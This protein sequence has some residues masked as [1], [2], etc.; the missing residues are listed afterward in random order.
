MDQTIYE[1]YQI[2]P[3]EARVE[4]NIRSLST[5]R[6]DFVNAQIAIHH[7]MFEAKEKLSLESQRRKLEIERLQLEL[8][9]ENQRSEREMKD[10][11]LLERA[12]VADLTETAGKRIEK[13]YAS[14]SQEAEAIRSSQRRQFFEEMAKLV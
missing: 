6:Q 14:R 13:L 7:R 9:L 12:M 1:S 10:L 8:N 3:I 11:H 4:S 5:W 2:N